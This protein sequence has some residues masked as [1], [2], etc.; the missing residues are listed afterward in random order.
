VCGM[1]PREAPRPDLNRPTM[2]MEK[3]KGEVKMRD[4]GIMHQGGRGIQWFNTHA[5][6]QKKLY[7]KNT[8]A[9]FTVGRPNDRVGSAAIMRIS[10]GSVFQTTVEFN[11]T[12]TAALMVQSSVLEVSSAS[13]IPFQTSL[14]IQL[15][16]DV[17]RITPSLLSL[18]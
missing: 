7:K 15:T 2:K 17:S 5:A 16:V 1:R 11:P 8:L 4:L 3:P 10:M 14:S 12:S 13:L 9:E 6:F 18:W